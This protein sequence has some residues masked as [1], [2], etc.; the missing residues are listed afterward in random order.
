MD[1]IEASGR[2]VEEAVQAAA[3]ELG[4]SVDDVEYEIV[5][6]GNKGFL[7]LGQ[8]PAIVHAWVSKDRSAPRQ[9]PAREV[10]PEAAAPVAEESE[11]ETEEPVAHP[12]APEKPEEI[13]ET[14]EI[15]EPVAQQRAPVASSEEGDFAGI[16]MSTLSD[17]LGAMKLDVKPVRKS[18]DGDEVTFELVGSDTSVLVGKQGQTLDALQY[19]VGI[20]ANRTVPTRKRVILDAEGYRDRH[21]DLLEKKAHEYAEAVKRE[22][23]EAVLEPQSAR[24]R[25]IIHLALAD[26]PDVY[27]YSEGEGDDRHV[28]IS[29][30]K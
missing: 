25:R 13:R 17:I 5:D 19:L 18:S 29:P 11:E 24:D 7:G 1:K 30:K 12:V 3:L 4:V 6:H 26:D 9:R 28:V 10:E 16:V 22:G 14:V 8:T 15:E 2:T 21:K 20:I 27:T 23:K